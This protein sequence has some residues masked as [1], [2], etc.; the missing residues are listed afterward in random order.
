M[1]PQQDL[2]GYKA[3]LV[4]FRATNFSQQVVL[5][6]KAETAPQAGSNSYKG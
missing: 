2:H 4:D 5:I 3:K 6:M 1:S